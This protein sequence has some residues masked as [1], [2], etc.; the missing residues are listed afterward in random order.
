MSML[1]EELRKEATTRVK[2]RRDLGAH[3]VTYVVVNG[4]FVLLWA[5]TGAG[6]FWPG[7]IMA[8]WGVGL[9]MNIWDVYFRKP[10]TEAD[11]Q[12]EMER[13]RK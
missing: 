4:M 6:Y 7:W 12:R 8:L 9:I 10:V 11:I 3:A 2:K 13:M 5:L 1:D